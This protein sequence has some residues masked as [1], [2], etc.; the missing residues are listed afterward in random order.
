V[1]LDAGEREARDDDAEDGKED[2]TQGCRCA[3]EVSI[4]RHGGKKVSQERSRKRSHVY[5][6]ETRQ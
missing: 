5:S 6:R 1:V 3:G 2:K 4:G